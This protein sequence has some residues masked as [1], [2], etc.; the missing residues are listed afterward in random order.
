MAKTFNGSIWGNLGNTVFREDALRR[1][2]NKEAMNNL[3]SAAQ[4]IEKVNSNRNLRND[5]QKYFKDRQEAAD[6]AAAQDLEDTLASEAIINDANEADQVVV[7]N[8]LNLFGVRDDLLGLRNDLSGSLWDPDNL[9]NGYTVKDDGADFME[10]FDPYTASPEEI[11]RA[12]AMIG[13][14]P[15]GVWGRKSRAAYRKFKGV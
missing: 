10:S 2:R 1:E 3:M 11:R 15:D 12:Q 9:V 14:T 4:F 13:V 5:W 7:P 8:K 6:M